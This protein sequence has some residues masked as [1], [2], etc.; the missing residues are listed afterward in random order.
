MKININTDTMNPEEILAV[1]RELHEIR[2]R[3]LKA[4]EL[5]ERMKDLLAEAKQNDFSFVGVNITP[6]FA[7]IS[8]FD[9]K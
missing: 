4:E 8:I 6:G 5:I 7:N 9:E 3:K 2:S 1:I